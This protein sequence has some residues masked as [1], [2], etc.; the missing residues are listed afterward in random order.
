[1]WE[2]ALHHSHA[3]AVLSAVREA[4]ERGRLRSSHGGAT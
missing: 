1:M 2:T 3:E 4:G